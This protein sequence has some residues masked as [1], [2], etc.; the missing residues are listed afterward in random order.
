MPQLSDRFGPIP[1]QVVL[2]GSGNGTISFQVNGSNARITNLYVM[3]SSSVN[4][5]TCTMYKGQVA[6]SN[7]IDSTNS[8]STGASA[9]GAIDLTDGETLFV[10]WSG[11]DPAATA[12]ATFTGVTIPFSEVGP[13]NIEWSDPIAA[14]DGSLVYP[15]LKSPNFA[16]GVSGWMI[17]R[18]G[19]AEFN[20][21]LVRGTVEVD[22]PGNSSIQIR[23][24]GIDTVIYFFPIDTGATDSISPGVVYVFVVDSA[25]QTYSMI[26]AAPVANTGPSSPAELILTSSDKAGATEP[27]VEVHGTLK[28]FVDTMLY[29]HGQT[30]TGATVVGAAATSIVTAGQTFTFPVA[31]PVG[32]TPNVHINMNN[33]AAN[34]A[35]WNARAVGITNTGFDIRGSGAAPGGT[36][37]TLGFQY[38]ATF[39]A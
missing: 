4:Q 9:K 2:D 25:T 15:A 18:N 31:F 36:G 26:V 11:G 7:I 1:Q 3:V 34:T 17:S 14:G 28:D 33:N 16:T 5:A 13:S 39:P 35:T 20:D 8:G 23:L 37:F 22:G 21:V 27:T 6:N 24:T 10:V 29:V 19:D 12:S 38:L 32:V 30:G